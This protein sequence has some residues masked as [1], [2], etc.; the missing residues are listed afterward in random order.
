MKKTIK[1][2]LAFVIAIG[3]ISGLAI[4]NCSEYVNAQDEEKP[5][6]TIEN[7]TPFEVKNVKVQLSKGKTVE[8]GTIGKK[9]SVKVPLEEGP[10]PIVQTKIQGRMP[11]AGKFD[12]TVTGW[13]K[14]GSRIQL[15]LD[16]ELKVYISSN[17]EDE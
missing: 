10:D 8:I 7:T 13:I 1:Q 16:D 9:E 17:V 5:S 3:V 4:F 15:H 11:L 12:G 14:A 6:L 2:V